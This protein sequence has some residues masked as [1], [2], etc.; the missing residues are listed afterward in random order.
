[1]TRTVE[2]E[3]AFDIRPGEVAVD[4]PGQTDAA[5]YFIGRLRTPWRSRAECPKRG[6]SEHGP[7]CT[8]E[9]APRWQAALAGIGRHEKLQILYWMHLARRDLVA[10]S[11]KSDGTTF[12]TFS[13]RSPVRPNPIASSVVRLVAVEGSKLLVRGLD[14]VDGTPL[15]DVKPEYCP[16]IGQAGEPANVNS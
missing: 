2:E 12:G 15:I 4:L 5:V 11:P 3:P 8:V 16:A 6:D 14:C 13:L 1:M 10:Q 9:I 7:V